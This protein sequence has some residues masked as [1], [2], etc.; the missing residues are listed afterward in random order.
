MR[1]TKISEIWGSHSGTCAD[2][3]CLACDAMLSDRYVQTVSK[4]QL[5]P[6]QRQQVSEKQQYIQQT[7]WHYIPQGSYHCKT[8]ICL[9][10]YMKKIWHSRKYTTTE[11]FQNVHLLD[12]WTIANCYT[13]ILFVPFNFHIDILQG[14]TQSL[15]STI[16]HQVRY[17]QLFENCLQHS[18]YPLVLKQFDIKLVQFHYWTST[19]CSY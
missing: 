9:S 4:N 7:I 17:L 8:L 11:S 14:F 10:I 2:N 6:S 12:S 5:L 16:R 19:Y 13:W 1:P 18:L 3:C 15:N